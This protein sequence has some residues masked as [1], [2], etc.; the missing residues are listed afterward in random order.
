M[1]R[2]HLRHLCH[3]WPWFSRVSS[4][5]LV[6]SACALRYNRRL[7]LPTIAW[8]EDDIVMVDQRKQPA[9]EEFVTCRT[10]NEV[11]KAIKTMVIRGRARPPARGSSR[12]S[13]SAIATC[14]RRPGQRP[15]TC[16][17]PSSG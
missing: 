6:R 5:A 17:G 16:F 4:V 1:P 9:Q 7:M 3:L 12:P 14:S 10:V 2:H 8:Q 15:S 11:A 13:S